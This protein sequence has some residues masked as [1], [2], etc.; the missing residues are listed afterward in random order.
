VDDGFVVFESRAICKYIAAQTG[1][2]ALVPAGDVKQVARFEQALSIEQANYDPFAQQIVRQRIVFPRF[3]RPTEEARVQEAAQT[4]EGKLVVYNQ[5]LSEQKYLAGD[6]LTMADLYH[7]PYGVHLLALGFTWL[8]D[9][10]RF[11][12]LAR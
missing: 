12:N 6:E 11:P 3:G 8:E 5:I 2:T 7:L 4:L 9:K 1:G 10:E